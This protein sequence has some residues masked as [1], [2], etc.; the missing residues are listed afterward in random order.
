MNEP[1]G[2]LD[3]TM[4]ADKGMPAVVHV[5]TQYNQPNYTLYDFMFGT[6]PR[7]S[8]PVMSSGSGVIISDDGYIRNNFV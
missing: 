6:T 5:K 3:F 1:A 2:T 8:T 7:Y 4:A